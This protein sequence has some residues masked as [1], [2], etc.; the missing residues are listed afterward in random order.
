M[1]NLVQP[2]GLLL[3]DQSEKSNST[4]R[5]QIYIWYYYQY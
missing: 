3:L 1:S 5:F 2:S 4:R